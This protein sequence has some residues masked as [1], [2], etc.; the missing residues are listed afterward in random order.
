MAVPI[1]HQVLVLLGDKVALVTGAT[2]G[3]GRVV[4]KRFLS[5]GAKVAAVYRSDIR[6]NEL[7]EYTGQPLNLRGFKADVTDALSVASLI[8]AVVKEYGRVD[9]LLNI[10][11]G[12]VG[13]KNL[14]E[15]DVADWDQMMTLNTKSAY[16]CCRAVLPRM[17]EKNYGK[18][19]S[20][21]SKNATPKGK[22]SGN[23]AYTVSKG[24]IIT[25][26]EALAD[27]VMKQDINVNCIIP[28]TID[29]PNNRAQ[30]PKADTSKWVS[31]LDIAE[32]IVFLSS[33]A[34][35]AVSGASIP[36]YWK[37]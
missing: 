37:S 31:P 34:S 19:V 33:D 28:S 29:T 11:G 35:R 15:T 23:V 2:G 20:V 12:Y 9:I 5:E 36:V 3:L 7:M 17:I 25:L 16:L 1:S 30:M 32:V 24:G 4:V 22:R 13:G 27:E 6:L 10:A 18:I 26:T 21:S 14:P 8:D